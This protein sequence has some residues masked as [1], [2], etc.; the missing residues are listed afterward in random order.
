M[1]AGMVVKLLHGEHGFEAV[2]KNLWEQAGAPDLAVAA[3]AGLL[4]LSTDAFDFAPQA[5]LQIEQYVETGTAA[6]LEPGGPLVSAATPNP[7]RR[8][9]PAGPAPRAGAR[10][11]C[12]GSTAC[13]T[14]STPR[15]RS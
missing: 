4:T 5:G 11:T 6:R 10:W 13:G 15:P 1:V 2:A 7:A 14:S 3:D 12:G 9:G 8:R